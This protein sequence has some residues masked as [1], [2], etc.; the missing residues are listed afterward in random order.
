MQKHRNKGKKNHLP[1]KTCPITQIVVMLSAWYSQ[2]L[3][4]LTEHQY[5]CLSCVSPCRPSLVLLWWLL[6]ELYLTLGPV[7]RRTHGGMGR[8]AFVSWSGITWSCKSLVRL[9]EDTEGK[10][11]WHTPQGWRKEEGTQSFNEHFRVKS[12]LTFEIV[13]MNLLQWTTSFEEMWEV[14]KY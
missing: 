3:V 12:T 4:T 6:L 9:G 13:N 1:N 2:V 10:S 11:R 14:R 7:C 8:P 5:V